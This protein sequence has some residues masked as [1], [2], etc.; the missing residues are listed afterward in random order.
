MS[1]H[2]TEYK[3]KKIKIDPVK[4]TNDEMINVEAPLP[5]NYGFFAGVIGKPNSGKTTLWLSL[6]NRK[7]K[8]YWKKFDKIFI[9]SASFKTI[10]SKIKLPDDRLIDGFDEEKLDEIINGKADEKEEKPPKILIIFDDVVAS[11]QKNM[12]SFLRLVYNRRHILGSCSII[13]ISQVYNRIPLEI[14]KVFQTLIVFSTGNK[15][16]IDSI[17]EDVSQLKRDEFDQLLKHC[18][19]NAHDFILIDVTNNEYFHNFNRLE[20]S[21][22]GKTISV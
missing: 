3:N 14:R 11:L 4:M 2:I 20:L 18:F 19:Q 12:K 8:C 10:S 6:I 7:G 5:N 17:Y 21:D 15:R 16:E 9:F 1:L 22:K 13:L